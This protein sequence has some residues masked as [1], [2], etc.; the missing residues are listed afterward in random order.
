MKAENHA[1][2]GG[3]DTMTIRTKPLFVPAFLA[4]WLTTFG[5][6]Q[7]ALDPTRDKILYAVATAHLDTQWNWTIQDTIDSYIPKTLTNN[8]TLFGRYSNYVFSFEGAFRYRLAKEYY[9]AWYGTM[10][11]YVAQGRWRV[12]GS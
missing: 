11:N 5:L 4:I 2:F 7:A 9:P 8:F 6:A 1:R 3:C 12:A 10:S